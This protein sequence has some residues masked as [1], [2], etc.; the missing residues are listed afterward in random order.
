[1]SGWRQPETR[2]QDPE[3]EGEKRI[4]QIG[5]DAMEVAEGV[6]RRWWVLLWMVPIG[7]KGCGRLEQQLPAAL[8]L[9]IVFRERFE[10]GVDPRMLGVHG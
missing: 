5:A 9:R 7:R 3:K 8:V 4:D 2:E 6:G 1:L 10:S